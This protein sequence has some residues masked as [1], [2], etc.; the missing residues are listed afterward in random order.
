MSCSRSPGL[1]AR[2]LLPHS[3]P[4]SPKKLAAARWR[5]RRCTPCSSAPPCFKCSKLRTHGLSQNEKAWASRVTGVSFPRC[6]RTLALALPLPFVASWP[7]NSDDASN[8]DIL[9]DNKGSIWIIGVVFLVVVGAPLAEELLFRGLILRVLQKSFGS[10][11]AVIASSILFAIPH[12]QP[13]ATWQETTVLLT[14]LGVVGMTLAIGAV[15]TNR[16][17]PSVIAHFFFNGASTIAA[18]AAG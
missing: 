4:D 5:P 8:T 7:A 9:I 6:P 13:G 12:W 14:A 1:W 3:L 11:F 2:P 16:L 17:G 18:F 10:I 15:L